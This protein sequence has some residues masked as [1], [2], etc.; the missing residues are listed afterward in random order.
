VEVNRVQIGGRQLTRDRAIGDLRRRG[1]RDIELPPGKFLDAPDRFFQRLLG[2]P[3]IL[4]IGMGEL[5]LQFVAGKIVNR[6]PQPRGCFL[7]Y[8]SCAR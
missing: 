7:P 6:L 1:G 4:G 8:R 2:P 3:D 5:L